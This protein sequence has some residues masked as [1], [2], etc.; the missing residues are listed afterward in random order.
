MRAVWTLA[1]AVALAACGGRGAE[2]D[3]AAA[4][5]P[6]P[7]EPA[8]DP[9]RLEV[10]AASATVPLG[11]DIVFAV[12]L[13]NTGSEPEPVSVPRIDHRSVTFRVRW[14]EGKIVD[15]VRIPVRYDERRGPMLE[16]PERLDLAPG[17]S[18][19]WEIRTVAVQAGKLSFTPLYRRQ[20][21]FKPQAAGAIDIEVTPTDAGDKLGLRLSTT[22]GPIVARF[23]PDVAYGTVENFASLAKRGF[24]DGLRIHRIVPGFMAQGGDPKGDGSGGPGWFI[25]G[26]TQ[27]VLRHERGVFSMAR[28]DDPNSAG[29]Q[30]FVML[31]SRTDLDGKY[32]TFAEM[33]EGEDTLKALEA[34]PVGPD[35]RGEVSVPKQPVVIDEAKL[36]LL[37]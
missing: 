26:E 32:A 3:D 5:D 10:K 18:R 27:L 9:I 4:G 7:A 37:R 21:E 15:I 8:G 24:F 22:H 29:S 6:D 13:T 11:D 30:F 12:R 2:D 16:P 31:A 36:V 28:M 20:G 33:V 17:E 23:R 14:G 34:V 1:A 19:E 35:A 25:R